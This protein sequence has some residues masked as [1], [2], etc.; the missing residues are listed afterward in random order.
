MNGVWIHMAATSLTIKRLALDLG[1]NMLTSLCSSMFAIPIFPDPAV[2]CAVT[3]HNKEGTIA[4]IIKLNVPRN[5]TRD[6]APGRQD[7]R[8]DSRSFE[9]FWVSLFYISEA[10]F[11]DP[12]VHAVYS[13]QCALLLV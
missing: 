7:V 6:H 1:I 13:A 11:C 9:A 10:R 2:S 12:V 3:K 4:N 5:D 8:D